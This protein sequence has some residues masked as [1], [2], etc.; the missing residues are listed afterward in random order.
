MELLLSLPAWTNRNFEFWDAQN[1]C[2]NYGWRKGIK[3]HWK[4]WLPLVSY[5]L[6]PCSFDGRLFRDGED[7]RLGRCSKCVCRDGTTQCFTASCQPLLCSQ[8]RTHRPSVF[9]SARAVSHADGRISRQI[10]CLT[11]GRFGKG[12]FDVW[13]WCGAVKSVSIHLLSVSSPVSSFPVILLLSC[14]CWLIKYS[15]CLKKLLFVL[16]CKNYVGLIRKCFISLGK[17]RKHKIFNGGLSS[18]TSVCGLRLKSLV[19]RSC[20][21]FYYRNSRNTVESS[22]MRIK[23]PFWLKEFRN[24]KQVQLK[25]KPQSTI[26]Y[27]C[28]CW[29]I[30]KTSKVS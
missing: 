22:Q 5:L 18:Q 26:P 21:L 12:S 28:L 9:P 6:E 16:Y 7:W 27:L 14:L 29:E 20:L 3:G 17:E 1:L 13:K 19:C 2:F 8:V 30:D 25:E 11:S 10:F 23:F 24:T 15:C 4:R